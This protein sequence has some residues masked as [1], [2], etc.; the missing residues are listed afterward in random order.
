MVHSASTVVS[1][2]V[3]QNYSKQQHPDQGCDGQT[4]AQRPLHLLP[5]FGFRHEDWMAMKPAWMADAKTV[6]SSMCFPIHC[7]PGATD[8]LKV[9]LLCSFKEPFPGRAQGSYCLPIQ[10]GYSP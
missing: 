7:L 1:S 2:W 4:E 9:C 3:D 5:L 10:I 6:P 8:D